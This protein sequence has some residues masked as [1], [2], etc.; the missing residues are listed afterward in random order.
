MRGCLV[1][2]ALLLIIAGCERA[3]QVRQ[4]EADANDADGSDVA[5][6]KQ[7]LEAER[8]GEL[9][10]GHPPVEDGER[11]PNEVA[12]VL[13]SGH[14]PVP[15]VT[16]PRTPPQDEPPAERDPDAVT[17][18]V[19]A[20]WTE[21]EPQSAMRAAEFRLP[22]DSADGE[23]GEMT[24]FIF[25]P[26]VGGDIDSNIQRWVGQFAGAEG[27]PLDDDAAEVAKRTVNGLTATV[28]DVSGT[29]QP[30][31]MTFR[32]SAPEPRPGFRLLG[33]IVETPKGNWF[34]KATGPQAVMDAQQEAFNIFVESV[35][36]ADANG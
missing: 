6:M 4:G 1:A 14:P 12:A 32:G 9:P 7:M 19:P 3:P 13:P 36:M 34:F 24:V 8:S 22:A 33:A 21:V 10:P 35:R 17:W 26:G 5:A 2:M 20:A 11:D 28:V 31:A 25:P 16:A 27:A 23:A 18:D 29:Y 30:S 15:G